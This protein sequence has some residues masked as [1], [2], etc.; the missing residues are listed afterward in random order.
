MLVVTEAD[1]LQL[2]EFIHANDCLAFDTETTGLNVRKDRVIGFSVSNE[3]SG[4]YVPL[5]SWDTTTEQLVAAGPGQAALNKILESLKWKRLLMW[6]ASF[7]V[8][9]SKQSLKSDLLPALYADVMLM[10]HTCNENLPV[11]GLKEVASI[12]WGIDVKAEKEAMQASIKANGGTAK[13]YYKADVSLLSRYAI[14]DTILTFKIFNHYKPILKAEGLEQFFFVDEVMPLYKEVTIPMEERGVYLDMPKLHQAL[15][16]INET[17]LRI[18]QG[19]QASIL[20]HLDLFTTWFLNKDYPLQTPTGKQP[21]WAKHYKTQL[22][23][24]MADVTAEHPDKANYMFNLQSKHHLK[25]L[26]FDTLK[27]EPLARTP[28]GLP[29]VDE[30]FL[31]LM[32]LK[33]DWCAKLIEFNK[34][35]KIKG[36]YLERFLEEQ[37]DGRFYPSFQQ[38]RT[39]SGRYSG[40]MQ[41]L[42][43]P[44]EAES[45][46]ES[47]IH[48]TSLIRELIVPSPGCTLVSADYEQ[49]EP[50]IFSHTSGDPA[51]QE[52]FRNGTDFYSTVAIRTEGIA[53]ASSNKQAENYLGKTNKAARQKAKA[54]ALGIAYGMTGYKLKFEIGCTDIEADQLVNDYLA[55]FPG[56]K[57]WMN[58][59]RNTVKIK[60]E[61]RT[62]SG[63]VRHM[64]QIKEIFEKYGPC[65]DNDLELWK[66]YHNVP[67]VY[68]EARS[69]RKLYKN[70][71]NNA[72]NFQVQGLAAS[73][74]NRAAIAIARQGIIPI[75]QVHDELVFDIPQQDRERISNIVKHTMQTI[76]PLSVPLRTEPQFGINYRLCK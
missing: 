45:A 36:T 53:T 16:E 4:F 60:G 23:A 70:L 38:H 32:A 75:A 66:R 63:R 29:Q 57:E 47:V 20:P 74:M 17:I 55:A 22:E 72:I 13:Q 52:I 68:A 61:I 67:S 62:Q 44:L 27:E 35:N 15:A 19:I 71:L 51:L 25:K 11:Y 58:A 30:E 42:P 24:W 28:T 50:T 6:N 14:Q 8:R 2:L 9:I 31:E 37:E 3:T 10:V 65:I 7:D 64:P 40:D 54:Y 21:A 59:S 26:F 12:H 41:Q 33:Y 43:R 48:F 1:A 73:I 76:M 34:L 5:F 39:V 69:A 46:T 56:L 18:E 49:L